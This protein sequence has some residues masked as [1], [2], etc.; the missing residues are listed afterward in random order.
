MNH[1]QST[2]SPNT[3]YTPAAAPPANPEAIQST[4][5]PK[6]EA[7]PRKSALTQ[8]DRLCAAPSNG[9]VLPRQGDRRQTTEP[10]TFGPDR[11][12]GWDRRQLL[13]QICHNPPSVPKDLSPEAAA[14][15]LNSDVAKNRDP[16]LSVDE[17]VRLHEKSPPA[18]NR[19]ITNKYA[20]EGTIASAVHVIATYLS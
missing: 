20:H 14:A 10:R 15:R 12:S 8:A 7:S 5:G 16:K 3:C 4:S 11:R 2:N 6:P 9:E 18:G 19:A 13:H 1:L 17:I